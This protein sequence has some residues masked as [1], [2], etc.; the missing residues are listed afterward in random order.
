MVIINADMH[1]HGRFSRATSKN[2]DFANLEKYARQKGLSLLGTGDFT[3]PKWS[4]DIKNTFREEN[5][6]LYTKTNFPFVLQT[7]ISLIFTDKILRKGKRIH[8]VIL[9]PSIEVTRQITDKLLEFGRVDYDGR[10]IFNIQPDD[11]VNYMREIDKR[12]EIIPAHVW[13]PWFGLFG[14]NSGYDKIED[15]F[16]DQTKHIHALETGLSS[17]P[18]MNWQLSTLDRFNLVSSSDCHSFWPWRLGRESTLFEL[19]D[20]TYDNLIK[21]HR[22]I[23]DK[24]ESNKILATMEF[25][26]EEGK[27]HYDGHRKCNFV[28]DPEK[29][30]ILNEVCPVCNKQLTLGVSYRVNQLADRKYGEISKTAKPFI[31]LI[32]LAELISFALKMSVS[33]KKV[34]ETYSKFIK[35]YGNEYNV[36]LNASKDS[37][38]DF[39]AKNSVHPIV[40]KVI[41]EN[42]NFNVFF[43]P[44][45][46]GE[47]GVV[48][49]NTDEKDDFH[50]RKLAYLRNIDQELRNK[51]LY[52]GF[53]DSNDNIKSNDSLSNYIK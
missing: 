33:S 35:H 12:I 29:T 10:P 25:W 26:P 9:A 47:Y 42:R 31:N 34:F 46:D 51:N 53:S 13:T 19:N 49:E 20:L 44:G 5:G 27:Y 11:F 40:I 6:I 8:V 23:D 32:P 38:L 1:I 43:K 17:D 45:Y 41:L 36:M 2:L 52:I 14:S 21:A 48:V 22:N 16:K 30:K 7:E 37:L 28:S 50:S 3:H 18:M 4:E 24:N 15:C 39:A